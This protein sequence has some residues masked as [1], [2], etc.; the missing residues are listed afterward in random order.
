M[1]NKC[2]FCLKEGDFPTGLCDDCGNTL[3][4][5]LIKD[6]ESNQN[7]NTMEVN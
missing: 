3:D 2:N 4:N 1:S 6:K 5:Y 7:T